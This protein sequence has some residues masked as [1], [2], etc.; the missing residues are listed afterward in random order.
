MVDARYGVQFDA[1]KFVQITASN[2]A[3]YEVTYNGG[4][5]N[6][7]F[8]YM[9]DGSPEINFH[10]YEVDTSIASVETPD[11]APHRAPV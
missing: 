1:V 11:F 8:V 6:H 2:E 10:D 9:L 5:K 7:A 3:Q 4:K